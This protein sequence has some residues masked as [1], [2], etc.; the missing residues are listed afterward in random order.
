MKNHLPIVAAAGAF[1]LGVVS[2]APGPYNQPSMLP[3]ADVE[4]VERQAPVTGTPN[5]GQHEAG[6][7]AVDYSNDRGYG[8]GYG[9][10]YGYPYGYRR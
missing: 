3:A 7:N 5:V 4:Q 10:G 6:R 8:Y 2:C 9:S 1:A